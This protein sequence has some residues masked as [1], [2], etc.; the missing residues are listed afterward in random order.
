MCHLLLTLL[1]S[2]SVTLSHAV[3]HI[4]VHNEVQH[5]IQLYSVSISIHVLLRIATVEAGNNPALGVTFPQPRFI[6]NV[7]HL[8]VGKIS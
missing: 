7:I 3:F 8:H 2:C 6:L 5:F 4:S 1:I